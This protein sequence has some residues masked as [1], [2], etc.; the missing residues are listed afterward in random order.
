MLQL[1]QRH[2][3]TRTCF[4][5]LVRVF[6]TTCSLGVAS[7]I[8]YRGAQWRGA[9]TVAHS[10]KR[11][12]YFGFFVFYC[13]TLHYITQHCA[14]VCTIKYTTPLHNNDTQIL[15]NTMAHCIFLIA[16]CPEINVIDFIF[17]NIIAL[18][19]RYIKSK[20]G[21]FNISA[22]ATTTKLMESIS[23]FHFYPLLS[24][25]ASQSHLI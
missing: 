8:V 11:A 12:S 13:K 22:I 23:T 1:G 18:T 9:E 2:A 15:M 6:L 25:D 14:T 24:S 20:V 21:L 16:K 10:F 17:P 19:F 5:A 7:K 3:Q 4:S